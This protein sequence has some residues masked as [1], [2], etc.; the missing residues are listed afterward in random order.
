M[1]LPSN[2]NPRDPKI[3]ENFEANTSHREMNNITKKLIAGKAK[4][5]HTAG[6]PR[7]SIPSIRANFYISEKKDANER[8]KHYQNIYPDAK[9]MK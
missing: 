4:Y 8:L 1:K 5:G 6:L 2:P 9:L 3:K 7:I